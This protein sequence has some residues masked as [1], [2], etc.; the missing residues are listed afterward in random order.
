MRRCARA[1]WVDTLDVRYRY[2]KS[3]YWFVPTSWHCNRLL[4]Q[5]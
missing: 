3:R 5:P 4:Y 2:R 1:A